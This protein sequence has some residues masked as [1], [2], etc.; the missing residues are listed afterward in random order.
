MIIIYALSDPKTPRDFR[1]V[2]KTHMTIKRRIAVHL[3][4]I[5]TKPDLYRSR[6]LRSIGGKPRVTVLTVTDL[7]HWEADERY[8]IARLGFLGY[9]LTNLTDGGEGVPGRI[10][11][12]EQ[13]EK[14]RLSAKLQMSNPE[15]RRKISQACQGNQHFLGRSHSEEAKAKIRAARS[16]QTPPTLGF[17]HTEETK[18]KMSLA[19]SNYRHSEET[20]EKLRKAWV[21]RRGRGRN[22]G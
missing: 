7:D 1:Y 19:S 9:R 17:H 15:N 21:T 20:R 5:I 18:K 11:S 8:W 2:G 14:L 3:R 16:F 10:A 13:R 6:W 12:D 22:V 4:N